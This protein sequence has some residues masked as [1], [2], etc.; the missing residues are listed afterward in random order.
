MKTVKILLIIALVFLLYI[1][2]RFFVKRTQTIVTLK[3]FCKKHNYSCKISPHCMLPLN[4]T[5]MFEWRDIYEN[6]NDRM[7]DF[8][9]L[10]LIVPFL[11]LSMHFPIWNGKNSPW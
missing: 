8:L 1:G 5:A 9:I 10:S 4:S 2:F 3:K 7:L 11:Y 6:Y